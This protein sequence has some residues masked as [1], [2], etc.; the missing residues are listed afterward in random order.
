MATE[1]STNVKEFI[2]RIITPIITPQFLIRLFVA[3]I[4]LGFGYALITPRFLDRILRGA[5]SDTQIYTEVVIMQVPFWDGKWTYG[6]EQSDMNY[7][8]RGAFYKQPF[9]EEEF[10]IMGLEECPLVTGDTAN[11]ITERW[12]VKAMYSMNGQNNE[13]SITMIRKDGNW[14]TSVGFSCR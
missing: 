8:S 4:F 2:F 6:V 12:L 9:P 11:A 7:F 13:T 3:V 14:V 1:Y 5:P 10:K